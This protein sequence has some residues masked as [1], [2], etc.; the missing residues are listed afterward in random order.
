MFIWADALREFLG[1]SSIE[2]GWKEPLSFASPPPA[3]PPRFCLGGIFCDA[4]AF[5]RSKEEPNRVLTRRLRLTV[6]MGLSEGSLGFL[7]FGTCHELPGRLMC[8]MLNHIICPHDH[9]DLNWQVSVTGK[10]KVN[11]VGRE[12]L[13]RLPFAAVIACLSVIHQGT[14]KGAYTVCH[15]GTHC[16]Q[17]RL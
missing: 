17:R 14:S 15:V 11:H 6:D 3:P 9:I 10:I 7:A 2:K 12:M 8:I 1:S 4:F 16:M 13:V 5:Q